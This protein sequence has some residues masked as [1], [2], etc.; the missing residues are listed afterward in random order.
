MFKKLIQISIG[1]SPKSPTKLNQKPNN[2]GMI[3]V[4]K[5]AVHM[6]STVINETLGIEY[7][8]FQG[9]MAWVAGLRSRQ[10]FQMPEG[11]E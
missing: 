1:M 10:E 6:I 7:P 8:I 4:G 3:S 5:G 11:W 9:G 2:F